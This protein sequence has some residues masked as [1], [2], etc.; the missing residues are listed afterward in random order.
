MQQWADLC[1]RS[2]PNDEL[3]RREFLQ[4]RLCQRADRQEQLRRLRGSVHLLAKLFERVMY[5]FAGE[6]WDTESV[7]WV[8]RQRA[9]RQEQLRRMRDKVRDRSDLL[10]RSVPAACWRRLREWN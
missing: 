2:L 9:N 6:L 7:Q 1:W 10:Q 4:R 8:V 3:R 5:R